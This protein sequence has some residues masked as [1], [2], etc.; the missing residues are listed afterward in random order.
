MLNDTGLAHT[1]DLSAH[2]FAEDDYY[3]DYAYSHLTD[4]WYTF[5]I[6]RNEYC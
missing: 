6:H 3:N 2:P 4:D 5:E 1:P